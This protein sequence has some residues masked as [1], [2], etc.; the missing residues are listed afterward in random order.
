MES[1]NELTNF[2]F[3]VGT[4]R[5]I[6][7]AHR[8]NLLSED[9]TDNISSHKFRVAW[10]GWFLAKLENADPYKIVMMCLL[11]DLPEARSNDQNWI[12]KN[13]V[14]VYE[15][16]IIADQ[17]KGIPA[18]EELQEIFS[19]YE[20]RESLE[21][22]LAKDADILD[23]ILLLKEH[24]HTGNKEAELWLELD[25]FENKSQQYLSLKTETAK[26]LAKKIVKAKVGDWWKSNWSKNRR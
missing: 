7:R 16:E 20:K 10:I 26:Q 15:D 14:K 18:S 22:V 5:K 21:S 3:E 6:P 23:Q 24:A 9:T 12:H 2:L 4:L 17:L 13:Y 25:D 11:H 1:L 8:Q 19:E